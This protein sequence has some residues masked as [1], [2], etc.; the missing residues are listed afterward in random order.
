MLRICAGFTNLSGHS[1]WSQIK[2]KKGALDQKRG[3][4]FSR[5]AKEI[6][7]AARHGGGD[8]DG[9]PRLRTIVE[10]AKANSMPNDNIEKAIL[11]GT[12]KL[13]G[14]TYDEI[15]YEGYG[16]GGI[17]VLVECLT[18][19]R[20]RT[21]ADVR[22]SFTKY[23]GNLGETGSVN[24]MFE[25]V[26]LIFV[27][28]SKVSEDALIEAALGAGADDVVSDDEEMFQVK[29]DPMRADEVARGLTEAGIAH[30]APEV[31]WLPKTWVTPEVPAARSGMKLVS[32]LEDNDDVQ[33][34][35]SNLE[36]PAE[37]LA[38][39]SR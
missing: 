24:W 10:K 30:E 12:G 18:D 6:V 15:A 26:G 20:N 7:V 27:K 32:A 2:R 9:N 1:K 28:K 16:P 3:A 8:P 13:E 23:G 34:V 21:T 36:P 22:H 35:Y 31:T 29:T 5:F 25:R 19:S 14:V 4:L 39:E 11:R 37:L 17:A 38:E 33:N